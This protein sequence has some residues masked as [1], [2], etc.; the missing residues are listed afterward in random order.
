M[1]RTP[2]AASLLARTTRVEGR[3]GLRR[4]LTKILLAR[5]H[6]CRHAP[7]RARGTGSGHPRGQVESK[8]SDI[9]GIVDGVVVEVG[10]GSGSGSI[11]LAFAFIKEWLNVPI[12]AG[13]V[14]SG[15]VGVTVVDH[16]DHRRVAQNFEKGARVSNLL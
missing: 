7:F 2:V 3:L 4:K 11:V 12:V 1:A 8:R 5:A 9:S 6:A 10:G 16:R 14:S 15:C 13:V